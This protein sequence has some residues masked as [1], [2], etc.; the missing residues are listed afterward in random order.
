VNYTPLNILSSLILIS[1]TVILFVDRMFIKEI[2][3][4]CH[5]YLK[6]KLHTEAYMQKKHPRPQCTK[7]T[8]SRHVKFCGLIPITC[9]LFSEHPPTQI[10][11]SSSTPFSK[12]TLL[13][14]V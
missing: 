11:F 6:E 7:V 5:W 12:Q 3:L 14:K 1:H 2:N 8:C 9:F 4:A 13:Y 10:G